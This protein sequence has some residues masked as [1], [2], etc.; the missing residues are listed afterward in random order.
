[1]FDPEV[2]ALAESVLAE[3]RARGWRIATAESCTGGLIAAALT[4]IAGASDVFE[5]GFVTYSNKAK[6]ELLGV[7][8]AM[9]AT[10]GAVNAETATAMA[11]GAVARAPVD[12]AV[13]ITGIAGPGGASAEK[14]VGLIFVGVARRGGAGRSERHVFPGDRTS[15]REAALRRALELL[16]AEA[17]V[18]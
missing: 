13:S 17:K 15:V 14:P 4:A 3:C 5:R 18:H 11:E 8:E 9:L 6:V 1:M 10:Q 2:L 7:S 16:L 12:V